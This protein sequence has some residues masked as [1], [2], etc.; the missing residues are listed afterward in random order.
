MYIVRVYIVR[1]YI[2]H[3]YMLHEFAL[4]SLAHLRGAQVLNL[5]KNLRQRKR[6]LHQAVQQ[7]LWHKV[8]GTTSACVCMSDLGTRHKVGVRIPQSLLECLSGGFP[9]RLQA[10]DHTLASLHSLLSQP[11]HLRHLGGDAHHAEESLMRAPEPQP[12]LGVGGLGALW[13]E[14]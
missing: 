5:K 7:L 6:L 11:H 1:V 3:V 9:G 12:E 8:V 10:D 4:A 13:R 2:V 14:A